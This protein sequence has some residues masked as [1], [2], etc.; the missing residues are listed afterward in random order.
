[1]HTAQYNRVPHGVFLRR[2]CP[3]VR[4]GAA[5]DR[6]VT[7]TEDAIGQVFLAPG[8]HLLGRGGQFRGIDYQGLIDS[9]RQFSFSVELENQQAAAVGNG[10]RGKGLTAN[11]SERTAPARHHRKV[12]GAVQAKGDRRRHYPGLGIECPQA[13]AGVCAVGHEFT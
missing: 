9:R 10:A 7:V 12:L 5:A 8:R 1:M 11:Q 3:Q 6:A 2:Q 13:F 4:C